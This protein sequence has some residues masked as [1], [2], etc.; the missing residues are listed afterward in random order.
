MFIRSPPS[1]GTPWIWG[2][3][4]LLGTPP[5]L[6]VTPPWGHWGP[7]RL[8]GAPPDYWGPP[9]TMEGPQYLLR[10]PQVWGPHGFG[11]PLCY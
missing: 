2:P 5:G 8:L 9:Q 3:A 4:L 6:L 7:P 1:L 10:A 11:D